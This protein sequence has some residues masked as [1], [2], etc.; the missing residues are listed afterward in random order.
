MTRGGALKKFY[1]GG[2][3]IGRARSA[4]FRRIRHNKVV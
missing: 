3:G 2:C 4:H 1:A